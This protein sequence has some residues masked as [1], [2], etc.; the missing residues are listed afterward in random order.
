MLE[1]G[2][3]YRVTYLQAVEGIVKEK[4]PPTV[5]FEVNGET[6]KILLK[7]V[8]M[9]TRILNHPDDVKSKNN[10]S[11]SNEDNDEGVNSYDNSF[12]KK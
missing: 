12:T 8:F 2:R 6:K 3:R 1:L 10:L 5:L 7:D 11:D 9:V 4:I